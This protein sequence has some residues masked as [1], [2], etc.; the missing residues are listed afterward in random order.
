VPSQFV[1]GCCSLLRGDAEPDHVAVDYADHP[2]A[3]SFAFGTSHGYGNPR[4]VRLDARLGACDLTLHEID[5]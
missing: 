4:G 3:G 5:G 2:S 1:C